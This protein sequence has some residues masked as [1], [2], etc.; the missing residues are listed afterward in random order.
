[1]T[2]TPPSSTLDVILSESEGSAFHKTTL[3][4]HSVAA[5]SYYENAALTTLRAALIVS[6]IKIRGV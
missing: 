6:A 5:E 1:M 3:T 2:V 4:Q